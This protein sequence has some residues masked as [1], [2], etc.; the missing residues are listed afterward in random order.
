MFLCRPE[1]LQGVVADCRGQYL[2]G[3]QM[4]WSWVHDPLPPHIA[5]KADGWKIE[6]LTFG[7]AEEYGS[8]RRSGIVFAGRLSSARGTVAGHGRRRGRQPGN[9]EALWGD[10]NPHFLCTW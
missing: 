5:A 3:S 2:S 8:V 9:E 1:G 6:T 4:V 7:A 10:A